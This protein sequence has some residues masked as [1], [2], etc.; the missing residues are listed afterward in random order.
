MLVEIGVS[1]SSSTPGCVTL[2]MR[3]ENY[4]NIARRAKTASATEVMLDVVQP[5]LSG[6][7]IALYERT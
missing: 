1:A 5:H 2:S 4:V 6:S 3:E 7:S